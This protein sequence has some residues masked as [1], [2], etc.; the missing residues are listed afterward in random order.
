MK[1]RVRSRR[2]IEAHIARLTQ[3]ESAI[4]TEIQKL[5][6]WGAEKIDGV[7]RFAKLAGREYED[8]RWR[9]HSLDL[10]RFRTSAMISALQ[11]AIGELSAPIPARLFS[12]TTKEAIA[13]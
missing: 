10:D 2:E 13:S 7:E 3:E 6:S 5:E 9:I 11:F 12:G 4:A 8:Y 1:S